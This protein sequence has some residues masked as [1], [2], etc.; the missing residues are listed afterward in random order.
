MKTKNVWYCGSC[1][2]KQSRWTG[3]CAGCNE[4]NTLQEEVETTSSQADTRRIP[5]SKEGASK[6]IRL[7]EISA[8]DTP[9]LKTEMK[10]VDRLLGGGIVDGALTLIGGDPGIGKSTLSLEIANN[11]AAQGH[12]VLYV[13]GEESL[14]QTSM[15]AKRV[16]CHSENLFFV[17][18]IEVGQILHH[19]EKL[20]P[21]CLIIDSIQIVYKAELASSPGSVSQVREAASTFMQLAKS[22]NI[23]T[24]LI[25]HVTKSGEI[26]GP[27]VLEHLVDTV[28]YFEGDKHNNLRLL[29]AI[30]NRFGPT[31]EVI[32]FQMTATGLKEVTNPSQIFLE[33]REKS[34]IGSVVTCALE[35]TRPILVEVQSLVTETYYEMPSRRSQGIDT[36][37]VALLIA[38][39]EK[40][41]RLQLYKYDV[42]VSIAGGL[43]LHEPASDLG[44]LMAMVSSYSNRSFDPGTLCVGEVGLGGE[45]RAVSRIESRVKEA[46]QMG[47]TR[48][49]VPKRCAKSL[50]QSDF[51]KSIEIVPVEWVD[52]AI[53]H[54]L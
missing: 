20:R 9:R 51:A 19:V 15:R 31:D 52:Q 44:I 26:A 29:R 24:F 41:S 10:E 1:G 2:H 43:R 53:K 13:S 22:L 33:E 46:I 6:P 32:V 4:W 45:I 18:E 54:I 38:V 3:Q 5:I 23:A 21:R 25:G 34:S 35:G 7:H 11:L 16:N 27:R 17:S 48:C 50:E 8:L 47:F 28:L 12:T 49:L 40:R 30:K 14:E 42:F 36:N 37:R 39:L